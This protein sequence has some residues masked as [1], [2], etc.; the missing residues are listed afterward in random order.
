[1]AEPIHVVT[2]EYN[3]YQSRRQRQGI[4]AVKWIVPIIL[5]GFGYVIFD[6]G[7]TYN[8]SDSWLGIV[9]ILIGLI[10]FGVAAYITFG[11]K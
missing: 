2:E 11:K 10:W 5:L 7:R 8:M 4:F 1:M 9:L 6:L 3:Q